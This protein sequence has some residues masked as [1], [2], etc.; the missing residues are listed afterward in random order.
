MKNIIFIAPPAA[1]KGTQAK[2]LSEEYS[3]PHI[4]TGDLLR[5]MAMLDNELGNFIKDELSKGNF[6][7]DEIITKLL[8]DRLQKEDCVN[9][10]ILDGY[11]RNVEQAINY[12]EL[13]KKLNYDIGL[14]IFL[15]ID[16]QTAIDRIKNRIVCP[17]CGSSYNT[18]VNQLTPK[19]NGIC[20]KCHSI[21]IKRDDDTEEVM[22][23]RFETY[24][25]KTSSLINYYRDKKVLL[26]IKINN[27]TTVIDVFNEIKHL[28]S[29]M[30]A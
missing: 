9:G 24:M 4:S 15:D 3:I 26:S 5:E 29:E 6:I 22:N 25:E 30:K 17:K 21:L 11:P 19:Q 23:S 13:L 12:E 10:Y 18:N 1:G 20:D 28:L 16:K 7:K 14:V 27:S 8:S 2:L